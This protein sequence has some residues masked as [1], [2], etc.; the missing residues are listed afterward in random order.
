MGLKG[1]SSLLLHMGKDNSLH[2]TTSVKNGISQCEFPGLSALHR[3][4]SLCA[5]PQ[6]LGVLVSSPGA[7][8]GMRFG[9]YPALVRMLKAAR[10]TGLRH[11]LQVS[12]TRAA[13]WETM[14][15]NHSPPV[16]GAHCCWPG[17]QRKAASQG[18]E[19]GDC[20]GWRGRQQIT[21]LLGNTV[22][23]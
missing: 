11:G 6:T 21:L 5:C 4:Q 18:Q 8:A 13:A 20:R 22:T 9:P 7:C 16:P 1:S 12:P 3:Q 17:P 14:Q 19:C 2:S 10:S 23:V 15:G